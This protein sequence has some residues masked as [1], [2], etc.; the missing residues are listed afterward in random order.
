MS[1]GLL[2]LHRL[3]SLL[4]DGM[5]LPP[6]VVC[7]PPR[8]YPNLPGENFCYFNAVLQF[9]MM[10]AAG[11]YSLMGNEDPDATTVESD[12]IELKKY[13]SACVHKRNRSIERR[14][15]NGTK[16]STNDDFLSQL[17]GEDSTAMLVAPP[18]E[19][20][21]KGLE[22]PLPVSR[23]HALMR[24]SWRCAVTAHLSTRKREMECLAVQPVDP[25]IS[26]AADRDHADEVN[27]VKALR[28][29]VASLNA[30]FREGAMNDAAEFFELFLTMLSEACDA[31]KSTP[32]KKRSRDDNVGPLHAYYFCQIEDSWT[33]RYEGCSACG[34]SKAE[35]RWESQLRPPVSLLLDHQRDGG[36]ALSFGKLLC[37]TRRYVLGDGE[38]RS[39]RLCGEPVLV[40]MRV[41]S[42]PSGI[43]AIHLMWESTRPQASDVSLLLRSVV[44]DVVDFGEVY[45][46]PVAE[47]PDG[48][49][50]L[51]Q[52][53]A[54]PPASKGYLTSMVLFK[55][56]H[57]V[58]VR[59]GVRGGVWFLVNDD[60]SHIVIGV[61][62]KSVVSYIES[63]KYAP[64]LLGYS[65]DA[66]PP[67]AEPSPRPLVVGTAVT[68]KE[69]PPNYSD[70]IKF[71]RASIP[72]Q[73][74]ATT[75]ERR[76]LSASEF[77]VSKVFENA[78]PQHVCAFTELQ[79]RFPSETKETLVRTLRQSDWNVALASTI[80]QQGSSPLASLLAPP[81]RSAVPTVHS[82][83]RGGVSVIS[84]P[85]HN[86][87]TSP[88]ANSLPPGLLQ[89]GSGAEGSAMSA[90]LRGTTRNRHL[91]G[92]TVFFVGDGI[93]KHS[94]QD[95]VESHGGTFTPSNS[96]TTAVD[97]IGLIDLDYL[98]ASVEAAV[99]RGSP[100]PAPGVS[101]LV[102]E[103]ASRNSLYSSKD[104]LA[105]FQADKSKASLRR[106]PLSA[107]VQKYLA[108]FR[109]PNP[110][111]DWATFNI[112]LKKLLD[113]SSGRD[114]PTPTKSVFAR[115]FSP[116]SNSP[117]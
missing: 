35:L 24:Y 88:G 27:S 30:E 77:A 42:L 56:S 93:T 5:V 38:S 29:A 85:L 10:G 13:V 95:T 39:C 106:S 110:N 54:R 58:I 60:L 74:P 81:R 111:P 37:A 49:I 78:P 117:R 94:V 45:A 12:I 105:A 23:V 73:P 17:L 87:M 103:I 65:L 66:V 70:F 15:A 47:G 62:W 43:H 16:H 46:P 107:A 40:A 31:P 8:G 32:G 55:S 112:Q 67:A 90:R 7:P 20:E 115:F 91:E 2:V 41:V 100:K 19:T 59:R 83:V 113:D 72:Q 99:R 98:K 36:T 48:V 1:V 75:S 22:C 51:E 53:D 80:L 21:E 6:D 71:Y 101:Q 114:E 96:P 68:A 52:G 9:I 84:Q 26:L 25:N 3:F 33:C 89:S 4:L 108:T 61:Q 14:S 11:V 97:V 76:Q 64:L 79:D 63:Q 104:G 109:G 18:V 116:F 57:Y 86:I 92:L 102:M 28:V 82:P 34:T 44:E 50:D 69:F